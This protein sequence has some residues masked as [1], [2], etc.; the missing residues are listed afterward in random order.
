MDIFLLK[1]YHEIKLPF[2]PPFYDKQADKYIEIVGPEAMVALDKHM[3]SRRHTV[4]KQYRYM[5]MLLNY[6]LFLE[7][8]TP[9]E[10]NDYFDNKL[11][12]NIFVLLH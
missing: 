12:C 3:G 5:V 9:K 11:K 1:K 8:L 4:T 7:G 6:K 2:E 10:A